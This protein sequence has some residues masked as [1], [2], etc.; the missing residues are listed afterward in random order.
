MNQPTNGQLLE[1]LLRTELAQK[2][3][4]GHI[5]LGIGA[6]LLVGALSPIG[7][8]PFAMAGLVAADAGR[9]VKKTHK[10]L[11]ASYHNPAI[12]Y[13]ALPKQEK[14]AVQQFCEVYPPQN[15]LGQ[16]KPQPLPSNRSQQLPREGAK[17][18]PGATATAASPTTTAK[19]EV[20]NGS[21]PREPQP[22]G[23]TTAMGDGWT[24]STISPV[25]IAEA[26]WMPQPLPMGFVEYL[27]SQIHILIAAT[28]GSGKTWLLRNLATYVS[29][30]GHHLVIADPKGTQWG[31]LSPAVLRMKSGSDYTALLRDLHRELETR[32][33]LLQQGKPVGPHLWAIFDE[34]MLFKG[35]AGALDASGRTAL[36]QRLLDIIAAGRELN[37]HLIMVNQ[38][39]MLGD[40]S[41]SGGKNTFSSGLRDNLCTLGLGCKTTKDNAGNPMQGNSKSI[42]NMLRDPYLV[43]DANDRADAAAYHAG[44]RRGNA[45]RTFCLYA[46]QLYI[47]QTPDLDI[48]KLERIQPFLKLKPVEARLHGDAWED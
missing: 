16:K 4:T 45:N 19:S 48:P 14:A 21:Q 34:W 7:W 9:R 44:M 24:S 38:S 2:M 13:E 27:G 25:D 12:L 5:P 8:L 3:P 15:P 10:V 26:G 47:G 41:L 18:T 33:E 23:T 20:T 32:I 22:S 11:T 31:E 17:A 40:L 6:F 28:T 42:D 39:H 1:D 37:M 36:E 35:K 43:S 30:Q 46:S 29:N